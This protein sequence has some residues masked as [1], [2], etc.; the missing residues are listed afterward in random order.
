MGYDVVVVGAGFAGSVMAERFARQ[1]RQAGARHRSPAARGRERLRRARRGRDPHPPLRPPHLPHELAE[2]SSTTCRRSP[3]GGRTSIASW[4][5]S[6]GSWCRSRSTGRRS[7]GCS[8]SALRTDDE[9]AAFYASRA[10]P[11]DAQADVRGRRRRRRRSRALRA[12]LPRL[13]AQAVGPRPEPAR[14]VGHGARADAD[15]RRRPLLHRS[16][17]ADAGRRLHRDVRTDARSPVGS[18]SAPRRRFPRDPR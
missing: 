8:V 2:T 6:A 14:R 5:A 9:V 13:H 1:L 15:Q 18:R 4:P 11:V 10:E 12:V 17:P 7:T 3:D 16:I